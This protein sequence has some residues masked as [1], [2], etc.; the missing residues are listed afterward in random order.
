MQ[1]VLLGSV[2]YLFP[3]S[4]TNDSHTVYAAFHTSHVTKDMLYGPWGD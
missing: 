2:A 4:H 3:A 1:F